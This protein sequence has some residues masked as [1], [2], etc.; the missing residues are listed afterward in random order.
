[1]AAPRHGTSAVAVLGEGRRGAGGRPLRA[2]AAR[3]PRTSAARPSSVMVSS[4]RVRNTSILSG[5]SG[6]PPAAA[7]RAA[8]RAPALREERVDAFVIE[9][10]DR[11]D[12]VQPVTSGLCAGFVCRTRAAKP[13]I[14]VRVLLTAKPR[15][16]DRVPG[17]QPRRRRY[18][19]CSRAS[20][21]SRS[22]RCRAIAPERT[23]PRPIRASPPRLARGRY[24][25]ADLPQY[26]PM[27]TRGGRR[28]TGS[29]RL[30]AAALTRVAAGGRGRARSTR[31]AMGAHCSSSA[32]ITGTASRW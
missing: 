8:Y 25:A 20:R 11:V 30:A 17:R 22:C 10:R 12:E 5:V 13:R 29:G 23:A 32:S 3:A 4:R 26:A 16:T 27:V 7:S 2:R 28:A 6:P 15:A 24:A 18:I 14:V 19:W 1:M 9:A 31:R 21:S